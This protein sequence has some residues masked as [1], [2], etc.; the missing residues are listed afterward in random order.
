MKKTEYFVKER[1]QR[2]PT[3]P[4]LVFRDDVLPALGLSIT[5]VAKELGISRQILHRILNGSHS[6]SPA[7]ALRLG[8]FCDTDPALWLRMQQAYD[9]KNVEIELRE[10]LKKIPVHSSMH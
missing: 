7:M 4:G 1:R 5:T 9:L 2:I 6:I 3:H 10:E 8:H